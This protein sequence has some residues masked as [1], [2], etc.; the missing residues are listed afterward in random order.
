MDSIIVKVLY[1]REKEE[2]ILTKIFLNSISE[3]NKETEMF[4]LNDY[5]FQFLEKRYPKDLV[6]QRGK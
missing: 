5:H 2:V 4:S 6:D 3:R 1:R